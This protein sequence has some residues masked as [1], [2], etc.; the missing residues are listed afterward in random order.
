MDTNWI[1]QLQLYNYKYA[2]YPTTEVSFLPGG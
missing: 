2:P 1:L